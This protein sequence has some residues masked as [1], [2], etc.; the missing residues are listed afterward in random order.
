MFQFLPT[1]MVIVG[2]SSAFLTDRHDYSPAFSSVIPSIA[3]KIIL[4]QF[5]R[6]EYYKWVAFGVLNNSYT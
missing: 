1:F 4:S 5:L 6:A 2:L 3:K